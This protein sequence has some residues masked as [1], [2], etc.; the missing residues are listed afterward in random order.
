MEYWGVF[1]GVTLN[2]T[3][4]NLPAGSTGCVEIDVD[5]LEQG[6]QISIRTRV[7]QP[8]FGILPAMDELDVVVGA[9]MITSG[10]FAGWYRVL[11]L[12]EVPVEARDRQ[13]Q[14]TQTRKCV[15]MQRSEDG[16]G[17]A[18]FMTS[19]ATRVRNDGLALELDLASPCPD[20][21][22]AEYR[23]LYVLEGGELVCPF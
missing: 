6:K 17:P 15:L 13:G 19:N 7:A 8:Q 3:D 12:T 21:L 16:F 5:P 10:E 14:P 1:G 18:F 4:G 2:F 22:P 11:S 23:S 20:Q 9:G